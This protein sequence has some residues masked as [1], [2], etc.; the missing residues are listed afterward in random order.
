MGQSDV[1]DHPEKTETVQTEVVPTPT[2]NDV[3]STT[4]ETAGGPPGMTKAKWLACIALALGYTTTFQQFACTGSIVR[5]IDLELGHSPQYNWMLAVYTLGLAVCLPVTGGL[6][7]IFGRRW[8]FMGGCVVSLIGTIV[9]VRADA[10]NMVIGGMALK[11]IGAAA[12]QLAVAGIAEIVPNKHRGTAQAILDIITTPWT[13]FGSLAGNAMVK[14]HHLT[15][16]INWY[17][18]IALNIVTLVMAFFFYFPPHHPNS[19]GKSKRQQF[20]EIDWIGVA[21]WASGLTMLL[22]GI[23]FGGVS[24][25]WKSAIVLCLILIGAA[26]LFVMGMWEW[27]FAP[28]PFMDRS[29]FSRGRTFSLVLVIIFVAGMGLYAGSA[30]WPQQISFMYDEDPIRIG[31]LTIAGGAGGATGGFVSGMI[32]GKHKWLKTHWCVLFGVFLKVVGPAGLTTLTPDTLSRAL[33]LTFLSGCGTGWVSVSLIVCIQL[34]CD[35]H[36]IGLASMLIGSFRAAGGTVALAIYSTVLSN[37][38]RQVIGK[39]IGGAVIPMG[40]K[41][42]DLARFITA[43]SAG[44]IKTA[45]TIPGA[46][47]EVLLAAKEASKWAYAEGFKALYITALSFAAF[48]FVVTLFTKDV[49]K[50]MTSHVAVRLENEAPVSDDE[51]EKAL[52]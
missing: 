5:H 48:A 26:L 12:Q 49:S 42:E 50:N 7:D 28:N 51:K 18:G 15:F 16:R 4:S 33:G 20:Y 31:V 8:F 43:I 17:V 1:V 24:Y 10:V 30:F 23:S 41:R 34:A 36:N 32:I 13:M 38:V 21:L 27:K 45:L 39:H 37:K 47:V 19:H 44:D 22:V 46:N 52:A 6:S 9:S 3:S 40:V 35:D 25:P 2:S 14:Y 11:G 29:L